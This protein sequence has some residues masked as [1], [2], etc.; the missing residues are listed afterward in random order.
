[1]LHNIVMSI[2]CSFFYATE[3]SKFKNMI[4]YY[5]KN[6]WNHLNDLAL[7]DLN[8]RGFLQL[9]ASSNLEHAKNATKKAV[10]PK[11]RF[12]PGT[13]SMRPIYPVKNAGLGKFQLKKLRQLLKHMTK[14]YDHGLVNF[15]CNSAFIDAWSKYN[16]THSHVK[17]LFLIKLDVIDAYGSI[18]HDVLMNIIEKAADQMP[19]TCS[20]GVYS[21][22]TNTGKCKNRKYYVML[23]ESGAMTEPICNNKALYQEVEIPIELN[24]AKAVQLIKAYV[25]EQ[26]VSAG[27]KRT[28]LVTKGIAQ[29]GAMSIDL[30]DL[31]YCALYYMYWRPILGPDDL[32]VRC[33]DD[34]L[35]I[36]SDKTSATKFLDISSKGVP[37]FNCYIN[38][39]KT[40]HNVTTKPTAIRVPFCGITVCSLT[41]QILV[42]S[43]QI[44]SYPPRYSLKLNIDHSQGEFVATRLEQITLARLKDLVIH[45]SYTTIPGLICNIYRVGIMTGARLEAMCSSILLQR[46]HA[47]S[48]FLG[49]KVIAAGFK[50]FGRIRNIWRRECHQEPP[51]S[52]DTVVVAFVG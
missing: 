26:R 47:N 38:Q 3:S 24:V 8:K 11:L 16:K 34:F 35:F 18:I 17:N 13:K 31:Y 52:Q 39:S 9:V 32:M 25:K 48:R 37:E 20:I 44:C 21:L 12:I 22:L 4:V 46:G 14:M 36:S 6:I 29:G 49:S 41:R 1:M 2:V 50:C 10:H 33:V 45:P 19:K 51:V 23:D 28:F 7:N 15:K 42:S 40:L 30:C 43:A 27:K 5:D